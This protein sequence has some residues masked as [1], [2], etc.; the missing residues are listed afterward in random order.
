MQALEEP[1]GAAIEAQ[2][3]LG[4]NQSTA[5]TNLLDWEAQCSDVAD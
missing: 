1:L 4:I 2:T 3:R 5:T